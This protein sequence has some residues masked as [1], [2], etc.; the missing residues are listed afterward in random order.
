[1]LVFMFVIVLSILNLDPSVSQLN[2][3]IDLG[4]NLW[5]TYTAIVV[6]LMFIHFIHGT[7]RVYGTLVQVITMFLLSLILKLACYILVNLIILL[8]LQLST[9]AGVTL[10]F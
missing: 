5:G 4:S 2:N 3:G 6:G 10:R 7:V 9:D 1:M 8:N